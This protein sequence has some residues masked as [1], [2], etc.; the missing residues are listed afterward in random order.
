MG[1]PFV[2]INESSASHSKKRTIHINVVEITN[3]QH[4]MLSVVLKDM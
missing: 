2:S 3:V 1:E 4:I